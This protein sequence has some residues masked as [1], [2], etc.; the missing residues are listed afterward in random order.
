MGD[1]PVEVQYLF[2][3]RTFC[4]VC[5][6]VNIQERAGKMPTR[7]TAVNQEAEWAEGAVG[8]GW[9][10]NFRGLLNTSRYCVRLTVE[11]IVRLYLRIKN[12]K[13]S[14]IVMLCPT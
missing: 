12:T 8:S 3:I 4:S 10:R 7:H 1:D 2:M 9:Q 13:S 14:G 11:D 6:H 5:A